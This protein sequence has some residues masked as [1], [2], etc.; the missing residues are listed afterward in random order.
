MFHAILDN[1]F[2]LRELIT[3]DVRERYIGS[4]LGLF[5]SVLNPL[6]QLI[7]YTLIFSVF[8]GLKFGADSGTGRFA[9][10]LFCGLLPW[11][12]LHESVSRS[13]RTFLDHNNLIKKV[14][15][16]LETLPFSRA[17]SALVHQGIASAIFALIL[18]AT[19]SLNPGTLY[20]V[21]PLFL[22][23]LVLMTGLGSVVAS[24]NVFF[25]DIAQVIG[26]GLMFLFWLTPIVY[27]K[28]RVPEGYLWLLDLNPMTHMVEAYRY[29]FFG[30]A[31]IGIWGL[32]YWGGFSI[33]A[34]LVGRVILKRTR[35][36][37]LDLV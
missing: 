32:A 5:W 17:A 7:L 4:A 34:L 24:L 27:P 3:R 36:S 35:G 25:R 20:W 1:R 28:T 23:Q 12:A 10:Y 29:A 16:P 6:A 9:E 37:I 8:L 15:F 2:L 31:E 21:A 22:I 26:V 13:A 30:R 33:L 11:T 19:G 18:V 14:S